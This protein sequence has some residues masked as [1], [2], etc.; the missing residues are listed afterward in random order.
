MAD[1]DANAARA[2]TARVVNQ[3]NRERVLINRVETTRVA[4]D[5][6]RLERQAK[7]LVAALIK[8][9]ATKGRTFI[10]PLTC[11]TFFENERGIAKEIAMD[12]VKQWLRDLGYTVRMYQ[13]YSDFHPRLEIEWD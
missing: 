12:H 2:I 7:P 3:R 10:G 9:A 8:D 4:Q 13:Y 1:F 11:Q 5:I 6:E